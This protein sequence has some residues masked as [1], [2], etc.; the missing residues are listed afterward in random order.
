MPFF[1]R[2]PD[3]ELEPCVNTSV[4]GHILKH[5]HTFSTR[6]CVSGHVTSGLGPL[7]S[8]QPYL[9]KATC[10]PSAR[11]WPPTPLLLPHSLRR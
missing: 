10:G 4:S 8:L 9:S 3:V 7:L 5:S 1:Q 2:K 6:V 11:L